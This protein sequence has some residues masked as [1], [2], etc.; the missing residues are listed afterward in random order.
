M[1][2]FPHLV[3]ALATLLLLCA[4]VGAAET[5]Q[6][7]APIHS[8]TDIAHEFSFYFDGRFARNYLSG[9]GNVD[10]RNWGTLHKCD[11]SRVNLLVLPTGASPCPYL[12]EDVKAVRA[13]LE[14]GGG[15]VLLG[16]HALFRKEKT[17]R[18]NELA[19]AFGA[20]F[21]KR[22]ARAPLSGVGELEGKPIKTYGGRTLRLIGAAKW[23]LLV[24][25]AAGNLVAARRKVGKGK[26]LVCSR[27]LAGHQPDAKDP[28]N[29]AWWQPLLRDLAS[30]KPVDPRRRPHH[31]EAENKESREGLEIRY[32]SYMKPFANE[33]LAIYRECRPA[34]ERIMGVPPAEGML[35]S[36]ILLPTGGGGFSS[37]RTIGLGTWWG[38]FPDKRYGMVELLG[39]E[40]T[41]S[42]V[43][44]FSEPMWNEGIATYVGIL[45]GRE[46]GYTKEADAT[47]ANWLKGAR[48]HDPEMKKFDLARGKDVPHAVRMAKPMWIWEQLRQEKPD[49]LARYFRLKRKLADPRK[50]KRYTADDS[51]AVLSQA[52]GRDLFPWFQSLG[53]RVDRQASQVPLP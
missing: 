6:P 47:L 10:V 36:L 7:H 38:G 32:S 19:G 52:M 37:G 8:V 20:E 27:A 44:P 3:W 14:E 35:A 53:I 21:A 48:R 5:V 9:K 25:D 42:W 23:D 49:V 30:G 13:F 1:H 2:P 24:R 50:L 15:V 41:H 4:G 28:I 22:A 46:L 33:I 45:L 26:L 31:M 51:V 43:L 16:D 12:P 29:A 17:Y 11:L 34:M 39:H 40:G 18:L